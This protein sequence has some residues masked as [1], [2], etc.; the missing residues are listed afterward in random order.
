MPEP[1][2]EGG[3]SRSVV[4]YVLEGQ[5]AVA[6]HAARLRSTFFEE[7]Y[8]SLPYGPNQSSQL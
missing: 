3:Y 8:L 2:A 5:W 6:M 1:E 7:V 4:R